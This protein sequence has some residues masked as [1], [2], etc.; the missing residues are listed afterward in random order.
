MRKSQLQLGVMGVF[1]KE[2]VNRQQIQGKK[3]IVDFHS[4]NIEDKN[5]IFKVIWPYIEQQNK[6]NTSSRN[7]F[8]HS[9]LM[10]FVVFI[11]FSIFFH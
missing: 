8:V 11:F 10:L 5:S 2:G 3:R 7:G 6:L 9:F 1:I 4:K